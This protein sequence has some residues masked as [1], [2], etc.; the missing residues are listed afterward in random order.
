MEP[1]NKNTQEHLNLGW[2][3]QVELDY[4]NEWKTKIME[5]ILSSNRDKLINNSENA[6][7]E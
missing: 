7:T 2:I 6:T 4:I 3:E 1:L 5:T